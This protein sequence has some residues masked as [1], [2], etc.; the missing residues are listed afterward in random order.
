MCMFREMVRVRPKPSIC[1]FSK[2][3]SVVVKMKHHYAALQ[4]LDEMRQLGGVLIDEYTMNIAINCY[5]QLNRVDFGFSILGSFLKLGH[6]PGII[7]FNTL[8]KEFF[9]ADKA[10]H[11]VEIF[12][13]L[14]RDKP[15][16]PN[17]VTF[18]A[19]INGLCKAGYT[20]MARDFG[21]RNL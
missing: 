3:L 21:K 9:L 17:E 4:M 7:T 5:C 10:S 12:K 8:I 2:L 15:C 14:S 13:K 18:L 20:L 19:V 16:V 1:A 6:E 11:A